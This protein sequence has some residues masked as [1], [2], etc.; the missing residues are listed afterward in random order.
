MFLRT[1]FFCLA[2]GAAVV[3]WFAMVLLL[4]YRA[5]LLDRHAA[6]ALASA[7]VGVRALTAHR[8]IAA[9]TAAAI[10]AEIDQ[11][12]DVELHVAAQIAF[13]AIV[14][15]DRVADLADVVL[16]EIV[17]L[18]VGRDAGFG[19]HDIRRVAADAVDV[20]ECDLDALVAREVD[21]CDASH[22]LTLTLLVARVA[23]DDPY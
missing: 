15:L 3:G 10:R 18:L 13:D 9:M 4:R 7:R 1:F 23:A 16:V 20:R 5:E 17:A 2:A 6:R 8:K 19:E 14:L 11:A 12:L 22:W 21:A